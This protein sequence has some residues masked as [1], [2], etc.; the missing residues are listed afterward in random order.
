MCVCVCVC[1]CVCFLS[2]GGCGSFLSGFQGRLTK[3]DLLFGFLELACFYGSL[4]VRIRVARVAWV[5]RARLGDS[6]SCNRFQAPPVQITSCWF[7]QGGEVLIQST[8]CH[9]PLPGL[10]ERAT[11]R[12]LG[13]CC[14]LARTWGLLLRE[15]CLREGRHAASGGAA[16]WHPRAVLRA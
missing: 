2:N 12:A 8:F 4:Q 6:S 9:Q 7:P 5:W 1:V 15:R 16:R 3:S 13:P 11:S 10:F 14:A